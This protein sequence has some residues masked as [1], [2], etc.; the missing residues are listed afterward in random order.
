MTE[1]NVYVRNILQSIQRLID[2]KVNVES[3]GSKVEEMRANLEELETDDRITGYYLT[4]CRWENI[5]DSAFRD[6]V[7]SQLRKGKLISAVRLCREQ[8]PGPLKYAKQAALA[9][10]SALNLEIP[11]LKKEL[12]EQAESFDIRW[13]STLHPE[14]RFLWMKQED[15]FIEFRIELQISGRTIPD[16]FSIIIIL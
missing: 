7:A 3:Y 5:A 4:A 2:R 15:S 6:A 13:H 11:P 10:R 1:K 14:K 12:E 8:Y 9:W 16:V